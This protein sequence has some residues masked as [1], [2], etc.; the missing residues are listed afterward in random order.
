MDATTFS[1]LV[2]AALI[3]A[4]A[5]GGLITSIL[6]GPRKKSLIKEEPYESGV[7]QI[8]KTRTEFNV[9]FFLL[10]LLFVLFDIET[11]LLAPYA[12][13][14]TADIEA[15]RGLEYLVVAGIFIGALGLGLLYEW[16]KG[17]L[18]WSIQFGH[19]AEDMRDA[20]AASNEKRG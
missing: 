4:V 2:Y 3:L 12:A 10:A 20:I 13:T 1:I 5:S 17:V 19:S 7:P 18:D 9:R 11:V 8:G 6:I 14:F 15:G 16:R